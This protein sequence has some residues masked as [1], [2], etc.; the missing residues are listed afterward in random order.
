[1]HQSFVLNAETVEC[2]LSLKR[3]YFSS[4]EFLSTAYGYG[5]SELISIFFAKPCAQ[6]FYRS[7]PMSRAEDLYTSGPHGLLSYCITAL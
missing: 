7:S 5:S 6:S 2:Q 3:Y 4:F 1:M